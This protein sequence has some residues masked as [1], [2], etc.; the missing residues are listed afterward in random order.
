MPRELTVHQLSKSF[1]RRRFL[2]APETV[3]VLDNITFFVAPGEVVWL[4]GPNGSGKTTLLKLLAAILTPDAGTITFGATDLAR[5]PVEAR[6][7]IG[8]F[9]GHERGLYQRLTA[10]QNLSLFGVLSRQGLPPD[11]GE[12]D[13]LL[14]SLN[15]EESLDHPVSQYSAGAKT[16]LELARALLHHP[17]LLLLDEPFHALDEKSQAALSFFLHAYAARGNIV[18]AAEHLTPAVFQPT[19]HLY[20]ESGH[21][22]DRGRP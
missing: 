12:I 11:P 10:R 3:H 9:L 5:G 21:L 14:Q 20:L 1:I 6:N 13:G 8:M 7:H 17:S 19:R 15:F 22:L 4:Q 16:K 2:V 18:F